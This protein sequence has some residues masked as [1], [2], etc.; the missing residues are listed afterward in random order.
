MKYRDLTPYGLSDPEAKAYLAILELGE[1]TVER[2]AKKT[3]I[4]R[5]SLYHTLGLLK[6][7]GLVTV[8]KRGARTV[9]IAEDPRVLKSDLE[10]KMKTLEQ[11]LPE[12]RSM[13]N[14]IDKKPRIRY[15]E[16]DAEMIEG[17]NDILKYPDRELLF[18][19][20]DPTSSLEYSNYWLH[21]F[22]PKRVNLSIFARA[23]VPNTRYGREMVEEDHKTLRRTRIDS[24]STFTPTADIQLYGG[25]KVNISS[26]RDMLALVIESKDI[27]DTLK[28]IFE[29]HWS[30][31]ES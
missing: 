17:I 2:I 29:S 9:Y 24:Q 5:T 14:V 4:V 11:V 10:E 12:L 26:H 19:T 23:I 16:G 15:Y 31:L 22:V 28:T 1:S 21:Y 13:T 27:H 18:W 3:R 7:R 20:S 25:N 6:T 30:S 8:A